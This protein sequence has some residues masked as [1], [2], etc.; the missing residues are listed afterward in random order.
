MHSAPDRS[1]A[2]TRTTGAVR[3]PR[4]DSLPFRFT[5]APNPPDRHHGPSQQADAITCVKGRQ[6]PIRMGRDAKRS[7]S[8]SYALDSGCC[9]GGGCC[10]TRVSS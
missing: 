10:R 4:P 1:P 6:V 9:A 5:F 7:V 8:R 3:S 2:P